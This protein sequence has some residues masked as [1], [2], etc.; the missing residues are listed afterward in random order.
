MKSKIG[1]YE[2]IS[3]VGEGGISIVYKALDPILKRNVALKVLKIMDPVLIRRFFREAR[4][5]AGIEHEN[6]CKVYDFGEIDGI[7]YITM[8]FIKGLPLQEAVKNMNL[9]RKLIIIKKVADALHEAHKNGLIHRDLKPSNIMVETKEDGEEK[10]YIIDFG[11]VKKMK[12]SD[13]TFPGMIVGTIGY[14]SPEQIEGKM[15]EIDRR[16]DIYG[17]GAVLFTILMGEPPFKGETFETLKEAMEKDPI[18][19]RRLNKNIPKDVEAIVMKCLEKDPEQRYQ[20]AKELSEDIDRF[21]KGEPAK[22]KRS[23]LL[24]RVYKK[25]KR[26]KKIF[27]FSSVAL[28]AITF[29]IF[30]LFYTQ[31]RED[32]KELLHGV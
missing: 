17:I 5:Q 1:R 12:E 16:T 21:L 15:D 23:S 27:T 6:I 18:P 25:A 19:L 7:P 13:S 3:K 29:L 26:N 31:H 22:A 2:I 30:L 8:Q 9:E 24:L 14:M 10:P 32:N 4:A 28:I 11:L 20:S